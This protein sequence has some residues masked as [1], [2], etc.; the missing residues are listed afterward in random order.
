ML[1]LVR[2]KQALVDQLGGKA[3]EKQQEATTA[4]K[5]KVDVMAAEKAALKERMQLEAAKKQ[6]AAKEEKQ[7]ADNALLE[8]AKSFYNGIVTPARPV[9]RPIK[10]ISQCMWVLHLVIACGYC[11]QSVHVGT[12]FSQCI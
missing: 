11:I 10:V 4:A 7:A 2:E 5:R 6:Q 1:Q 9:V 3:L 12:V 8:N